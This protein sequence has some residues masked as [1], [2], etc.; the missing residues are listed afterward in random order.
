MGVYGVTVADVAAEVPGPFPTGFSAATKPTA[1]Q[2][3]R[4]IDRED[5]RVSLRVRDLTGAEPALTDAAAG[6]A[7]DL[8]I[9]GVIS[10]ILRV[11]YTGRGVDQLT[12]ALAPYAVVIAASEAEL[13]NLGAQASGTGAAAPRLAMP[14]GLPARDLIVNDAELDG[15]ESFRWRRF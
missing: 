7:I 1:Q 6:S 9:A 15:N 13:T 12:A 4:W 10:R 14:T 3:Q 8:I 5:A 2:V 11:V